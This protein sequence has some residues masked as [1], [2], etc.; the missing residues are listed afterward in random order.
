LRNPQAPSKKNVTIAPY[1]SNYKG[2]GGYSYKH[3]LQVLKTSPL[4][5]TACAFIAYMTT[6]KEGYVAWGKDM[7][8]YCTNPSIMQDHSKDGYVKGVNTFAVKNDKPF[9]WWASDTGGR[10]VVEDPTYCAKVSGQMSDW[11]DTSIGGKG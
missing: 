6:D 7:G 1:Q 10:L 9:S 11:I 2:I 5:W 4:P 8:S 3:Y